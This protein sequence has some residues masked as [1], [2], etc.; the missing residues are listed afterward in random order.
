MSTKLIMTH[1]PADLRDGVLDG[2]DVGLELV[3]VLAG[4]DPERLEAGGQDALEAR[5]LVDSGPHH[6]PATSDTSH[7]QHTSESSSRATPPHNLHTW[8]SWAGP[9]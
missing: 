7:V 1:R 3:A 2:G 6:V 5:L 8:R 4:L 9:S